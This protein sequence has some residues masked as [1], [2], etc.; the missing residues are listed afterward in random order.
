MRASSCRRGNIVA[1]I[2]SKTFFSFC[3]HNICCIWVDSE[4]SL[5]PNRSV[6]ENFRNMFFLRLPCRECAGVAGGGG[7]LSSI[8]CVVVWFFE[9]FWIFNHFSLRVQSEKGYG[10]WR[11]G[12]KTYGYWKITTFSPEQ[13]PSLEN[14]VGGPPSNMSHFDVSTS[15]CQF[16]KTT[17]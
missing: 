7:K 1:N 14:R 3:A 2:A 16:G 9:P 17:K 6:S 13:G 8:S 5:N 11:S 12:L 4:I 15:M 10:F